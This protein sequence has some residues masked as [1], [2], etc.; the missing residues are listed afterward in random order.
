ML[1]PGREGESLGNAREKILV[2]D[3]QVAN[4]R[5]LHT[6]LENDY[7][8]FMATEGEQAVELC[9]RVN[10]DLV[11]LDVIMPGVGGHDVCRRLKA[12]K[13]TQDIPVIFV[14]SQS[15]DAD[16][17]L[18]LSLGAVDFISKPIRPA[19]TLRRIQTH[20]TLKRQRDLLRLRAVTD[21]LT[22]IANRRCFN[23]EAD[24]LWMQCA[25]ELR[26][27]SLLMMDVDY[28]KRYN[29]RYGHQAGDECLFRVAAAIAEGLQ[30]PFDLLAR[31]GGEE[32][33]CILP[34]TD[35]RGARNVAERILANVRGLNIEHRDSEAANVVTL[36]IG[37]ATMLAE[38]GRDIGDLLRAADE[39]LYRA[40]REGR[41]RLVS[42]DLS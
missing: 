5:V 32:F 14:T 13:R 30:R 26:P 40:K 17:E 35:E 27:V 6:L 4:I 41:A 33:S 3:D 2:V 15:E 10:P 20:L 7:E 25:R 12:D 22:G 16:E 28:F 34:Y 31:Y 8:V 42:V 19:V 37:S 38:P 21:A 18:G 39:Q 24:S 1:T 36:S 29:D 23:E 9:R 11:L